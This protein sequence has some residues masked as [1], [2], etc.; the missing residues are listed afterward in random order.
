MSL[1]AGPMKREM[2]QTVDR[3]KEEFNTAERLSIYE[4]CIETAKAANIVVTI[5]PEELTMLDTDGGGRYTHYTVIISHTT[6]F[7][8]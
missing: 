4:Y 6:V 7:Y 3:E 2:P 5:P 8:Q 1:L